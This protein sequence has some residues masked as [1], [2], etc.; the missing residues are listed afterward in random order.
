MTNLFIILWFIMTLLFFVA[1]IRPAVFAHITKK[2]YSRKQL[3]TFF[4]VLGAIFFVG[5]GITAPPVP[6]KTTASKPVTRAKGP[7]T[8]IEKVQE[9]KT[10]PFESKTED[11]STL[12]KGQTSIKQKGVNGTKTLYYEVTYID[13]KQTSKKLVSEKVTT[14]PIAQIT[15]NGTYVAPALTPAPPAPTTGT[16]PNPQPTSD[17]YYANCTAVRNAGAAPLYRGQPGYRSALD[18]DGDGVACE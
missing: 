12:T 15:T 4:L 13:G 16:T 1:I 6:Q 18:R 3:I 8:R 11:S 10:V 7:T 5:I 17:V 2:A 9:T 14:Q